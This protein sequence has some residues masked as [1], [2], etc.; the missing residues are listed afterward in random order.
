MSPQRLSECAVSNVDHPLPNS[1]EAKIDKS[2]S[3]KIEPK[4]DS[5]VMPTGSTSPEH[6][7]KLEPADQE[8][9]E[10]ISTESQI[11]E[12][13]SQVSPLDA[14]PQKLIVSAS[15]PQK[16][17][18]PIDNVA[19]AGQ[20]SCS[21]STAPLVSST[22]L[23]PPAASKPSGPSVPV[24]TAKQSAH[25]QQSRP[26]QTNKSTTAPIANPF[27]IHKIKT[28][29]LKSFKGILHEEDEEGKTKPVDSLSVSQE[30]LEILSDS[31]DSSLETPDWLKEEE[32]VTVGAN[33][34]GTVR[35]VG[36][37]DFAKGVWVGVEL[38]VP[39]GW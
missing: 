2:T 28:S 17:N 22:P 14:S 9:G 37:T 8:H 32:Y 34:T 25:S 15:L 13:H 6:Q 31:E 20:T 38:D 16:T 1:T 10:Q 19:S 39:A 35:Y 21:G 23:A 24:K 4:T 36:P 33:K 27:Q 26:E 5:V 18:D 29:G 12:G 30:R 7:S 3:K 11:S